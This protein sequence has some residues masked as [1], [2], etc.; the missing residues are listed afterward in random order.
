L[1][2]VNGKSLL[3]TQ[4]DEFNQLGIKD[5]TVVRGFQK[6]KVKFNN[7]KTV[8]NDEFASTKELY[9]LF[10]AK[11]QIKD[12]SVI[13]YGDIV[14][15]R[16]VLHELLNDQNNITIVVDAEYADGTDK[17]FVA[18]SSKYERTNYIGT[19]TFKKM[20]SD[21]PKNEIFGEFIGLWKVNKVGAAQVNEVLERLS[22]TSNFKSMTCT[23]LFNEI[24]KEHPIA[25]KYI[26]GAWLD[27]DTLVDYQNAGKLR[28]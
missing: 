19:A 26:S 11:D 9:S 28:L 18:A 17:D 24:S 20:G 25:V 15:K 23:D 12:N 4:V 16:Y 7:I 10:L 2:E 6:Q 14:F 21:L 22:K 5:I 3:A 13:S 1:L 8:D 27:V